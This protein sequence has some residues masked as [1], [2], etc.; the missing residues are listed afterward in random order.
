MRIWRRERAAT[1]SSW[2]TTS[3]VMPPALSDSS[4]ASTSAPDTWSRL[5]VGSSASST[6]GRI[7]IA[8]AIATRWRCPPESCVGTVVRAVGEA[9][10]SRAPP[11]ARA[12]ALGR[13]VPASTIGSST[14]SKAVRRGTRWNDWKMKPMRRART[15]ASASSLELDVVSRPSST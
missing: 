14:F 2:V 7:T 5:P 6:V 4:A 10:R 12:R 9:E 11:P 15:S 8:R 3:S 1:S 13:R